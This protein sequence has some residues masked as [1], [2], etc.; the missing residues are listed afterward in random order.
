V[1]N[2]VLIF[3]IFSLAPG[4]KSRPSNGVLA[5]EMEIANVGVYVC[6]ESANNFG[7]A[8]KSCV[9]GSRYNDSWLYFMLFNYERNSVHICRMGKLA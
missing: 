9:Y 2:D 1:R 6:L 4:P 3:S 8:L 5:V 7:M